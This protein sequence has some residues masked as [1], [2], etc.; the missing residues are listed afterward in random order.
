MARNQWQRS[1]R[2]ARLSRAPRRQPPRRG[3]SESVNHLLPVACRMGNRA[4]A[5]RKRKLVSTLVP[6]AWGLR[7][8]VVFARKFAKRLPIA[9]ATAVPRKEYA[10]DGLPRYRV[11]TPSFARFRVIMADFDALHPV[12]VR[13]L[14]RRG[15]CCL[16]EPIARNRVRRR[17]NALVVI[18]KTGFVLPY[19]LRKDA[20]TAG[21]EVFI[22]LFA[23]LHTRRRGSSPK[24]GGE[25]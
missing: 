8:K 12:R 5:A 16:A 9:V 25:V 2:H 1:L 21:N 24:T 18:A 17:A 20:P 6:R 3:P 14:V 11:K 15:L 22:A 13:V 23:P 10:T 4:C 7:R 19:V